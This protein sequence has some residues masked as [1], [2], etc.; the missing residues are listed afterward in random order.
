LVDPAASAPQE[1]WRGRVGVVDHE[2]GLLARAALIEVQALARQ[3]AARIPL[4]DRL[5]VAK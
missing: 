4:A 5:G 3:V 2:I 1:H